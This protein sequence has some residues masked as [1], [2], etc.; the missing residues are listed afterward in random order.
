MVNTA[1]DLLVAS[2][3]GTLQNLMP[4]AALGDTRGLSVL[5]AGCGRGVQ[6]RHP[7]NADS[8]LGIDFSWEGLTRFPKTCLRIRRL[9]SGVT[10]YCSDARPRSCVRRCAELP[11][12]VAPADR[13]P[14]ISVSGASCAGRL[15]PGGRLIVTAMHYSFRYH[16][17]DRPR[18]KLRS[19]APFT[20]ALKLRSCAI[21]F[22]NTSRLS[23]YKG[24]G[25]I[26]PKPIGFSWRF[27]SWKVYWGPDLKRSMPLS[28]LME[29]I[30][31][32]SRSHR[33]LDRRAIV[34]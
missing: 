8:F 25:S 16:S 22:P 23:P 4:S 21:C 18:R 33:S 1:Q 19:T 30:S 34:S 3:L 10:S 28:L 29:S 2:T 15:G 13:E 17:E 26:S 11:S 24:I 20:I 32:L 27:G 31:W 9:G 14:P 5:D 7:E 6:P 12:P